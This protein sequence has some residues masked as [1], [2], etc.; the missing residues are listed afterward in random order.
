MITSIK[1]NQTGWTQVICSHTTR[2]RKVT[3]TSARSQLKL[4]LFMI[5]QNQLN[6]LTDAINIHRSSKSVIEN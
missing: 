2:C 3:L 1:I 5:V 4:R 6:V